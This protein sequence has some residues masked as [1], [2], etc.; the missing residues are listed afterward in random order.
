VKRALIASLLMLGAT[1]ST[2]SG[3]P[4]LTPLPFAMTTPLQYSCGTAPGFCPNPTDPAETSTA[5]VPTA[6]CHVVDGTADRR[7]TPGALNP[8]VTQAN[9]GTTICVKGWTATVRPP[10]AYTNALK[11][12]QMV[13]YG[14][15]GLPSGVEEDHLIPLEV[16]GSPTDPRNLWPESWTGTPNAHTK[17]LQENAVHAAICAGRITLKQGQDQ[18]IAKWSR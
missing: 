17:D 5:P 12:K 11:R 7:C 16:G 8:N 13:Q 15:N 18:I 1:A 14:E 4:M 3:S 2:P 10:V 6:A 9:I